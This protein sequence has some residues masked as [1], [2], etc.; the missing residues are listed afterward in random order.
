MFYT[1]LA[2]GQA[3]V[4]SSGNAMYVYSGVLKLL[5][6]TLKLERVQNGPTSPLTHEIADLCIEP[7]FR[8]IP[9]I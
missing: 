6:C 2:A 7:Y 3:L 8:S 4:T 9:E 5:T 1:H